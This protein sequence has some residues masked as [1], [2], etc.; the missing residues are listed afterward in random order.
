MKYFRIRT[1]DNGEN[2]LMEENFPRVFF[3]TA[4][5]FIDVSTLELPLE[6]LMHA[7]DEY[8]YDQ[9]DPDFDGE[10][11]ELSIEDR[12]GDYYSECSLMTPKLIDVLRKAGVDNL[13]VF[14]AKVL[15]A[16]T[17]E[18]IS[19]PFSFVNV[20]GLVSCA[21]MDESEH[22]PLGSINYFHELVID[23]ER[24]KGALM[25]RLAESRFEVIVAEPVAEA[26][27]TGNLKGIVAD[28]I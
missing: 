10:I 14:E 7:G 6:Y 28:P 8:G 22:S 17:G 4:G 26:I 5:S 25:F 3:P 12:L 16:K 24:A 9:F 1:P 11:E 19:V 18:E 13:Q 20:L 15:D 2:V 27:N 21:N 23:E